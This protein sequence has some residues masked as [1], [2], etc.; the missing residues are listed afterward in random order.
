MS[1]RKRKTSSGK[2]TTEYH[3]EFMQSCKRYY[4]VC[5][6]CSTER[7][8]IAYEKT[9]KENVKKLAEQKSLGALIENFKNEL[10]GGDRITLDNA[11]EL[12]LAKPGRKSP[13]VKQIKS[14]KS[15]WNDFLA[16]MKEN[17]PETDQ[18]DKVTRQQAESYIKQLK[19]SGRFI[20]TINYNAKRHG[21]KVELKYNT[22]NKLSVRTINAF[23]KTL[24]S[25]FSRLKEDAG[26]LYNPF[27]FEML[28]KNSESRE[29]FSQDE[30]KINR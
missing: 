11:F 3:Y 5:E 20:C 28:Q 2:Q 12:Y 4:G 22:L 6:G 29:A 30:F 8:A 1:I 25:V 24:K 15:Q 19:E 17:Y 21:K 10:S 16:F 7:A 14:N 9:V 18:L 23:H 26:I 13:N 27:D